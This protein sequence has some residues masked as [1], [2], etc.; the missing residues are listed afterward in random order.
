MLQHQ[1][2]AVIKGA[3]SSKICKQLRFEGIEELR[4]AQGSILYHA[5]RMVPEFFQSSVRSP[6]CRHVLN[7]PMTT[8]ARIA[9]KHS[10][11]AVVNQ[12]NLSPQMNLVEMNHTVTLP[13]AQSQDAHTDISPVADQSLFTLWLAVQDVTIDMGPT[14]IW[15]NSHNLAKEYLINEMKWD[16]GENA[17][18]HRYNSTAI[19]YDTMGEVDSKP[20]TTDRRNATTKYSEFQNVITSGGSSHVTLMA[21]DLAVMD[22]RAWHRGSANTSLVDRYLFNMTFQG[23]DIGHELEYTSSPSNTAT[24]TATTT[25]THAGGS[26]NGSG[27]ANANDS[28]KK[29]Y[30]FTYDSHSTT[31]ISSGKGLRMIDFIEAVV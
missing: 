16:I 24:T 18:S 13:G 31:S 12:C 8:S 2:F 28:R 6:R 17:E 1:G 20:D 3:V 23:Q 22:C 11:L 29:L 15:I 30:G 25:A 9:L 5:K 7:C 4:K 26:G 21:G 14:E 19:L 27:S 10:C